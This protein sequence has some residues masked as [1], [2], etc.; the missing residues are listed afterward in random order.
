[1]KTI[2]PN[3][4]APKNLTT[5]VACTDEEL[6]HDFRVSGNRESFAALVKRYERELYSYLRRY[7]G[8]A[9]LAE[10]SFQLTFLQV[11]LKAQQFEEGRKVKPW[12]YAVATNQA[13]DAQRRNRRHKMTSLDRPFSSGENDDLGNLLEML[14]S[15]ELGPAVQVS[16]FERREWMDQTIS[17]LPEGLRE[18][19]TL[20][21]FQEMKYREAAEVLKIPVGTVK[22]RLH[23][24]VARLSDAWKHRI[25]DL[26]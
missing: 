7:L 10:D 12:L 3:S 21:Y 6:L 20:V 14:V 17:E 1:M 25:A 8:D 15:H 5:D 4:V 11:Y 26:V 13:I 19:V 22:S 24:A 9:E 18:V 16:E 2:I 23:A